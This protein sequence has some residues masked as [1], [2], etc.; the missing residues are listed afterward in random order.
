[1]KYKHALFLYPYGVQKTTTASV[2]R[3]FPPTG[4]EYIATSAKGFAD[5]ITLLDLR[6]EKEFHNTEKLLNFLRESIDIICVSIG[7][8]REFMEIC[9][10]LNLM[11]NNIPLIVGGYKATEQVEEL[12][13]ICPNI[14]IIVRGEGEETIRDIL[15]GMPEEKIPGISYRKDGMVFHNKIRPLPPIDIIEYPDRS[16]RRNNYQLSLYGMKITDLKFDTVLSARG[17][18]F[19]CKFCTF[20]LNP[21]GQK[22]PYTERSVNSVVEEI[23][24]MKA[25]VI[26]FSDDN[27]VTNAKRASSICDEIIKRK[28][29]KRFLAQVRIEIA[30]HPFLIQKM[31]EA[32]FKMLSIGIESPHDHILAQLDKGFNRAMLRESFKVLK[33]YPIFYHGYFIYGNIGETEDEMLYIAKFAR[34]L[35]VD[36]IACNKL[37]ADKFSPIKKILENMPEYHLTEKGEVYSDKYSHAD[38]KRINKKIKYS[39]Y[40]PFKAACI[41]NKFLRANFFRPEDLISI[42]RTLPFIFKKIISR[43]QQKAALRRA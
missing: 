32:G 37:R 14:D 24:G 41:L 16:L 3:L 29:K 23:Q 20:S 35:G 6:Y 22:R 42:S 15:S 12:F 4:L 25:D 43:E 7:W 27:F 26:L 28:I 40:T 19:N 38:L 1:M 31:V 21:L 30:K 11:P 2:N 18:P 33:K 9:S 10:L 13:Q 34:E 36:T 8:D 39:F 17:C 5:K